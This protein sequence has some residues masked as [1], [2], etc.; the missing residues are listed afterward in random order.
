MKIASSSLR[1][2][3]RLK[4][5]TKCAQKHTY[6]LFIHTLFFSAI[7]LF[8]LPFMSLFIASL[9]SGSNGNCYYVGNHS[10]AVLI[11]AGI[12]C[13]EIERRMKR[14]DLS[15][16]KL[17]AVFISHEHADHTSGI[18]IFSKKHKLPVYITQQTLRYAG[19]SIEKQ[20]ITLLTMHLPVA[21]G[22]LNITAFPKLHDAAEPC[23][24]IV[25]HEGVVAGVFTDI[26]SPCE[27]VIKYFR[28]CHAAFLE[29]NYD[30]EM[31]RNGGYPFI[32]KKRISSDVGHL[33]N[34][35]A[36][37]LFKKH[38][39]PHMSHLFLSHLSKNNNSVPLVQQL[40]DAHAEN[41]HVV[42]AS[43]YHETHVYEI[44]VEMRGSEKAR[45]RVKATQLVF[46]F[47]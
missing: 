28:Q 10:E 13:R 40:F 46:E 8:S 27:Q 20:L 7:K 39:P 15:I 4:R 37:A 45:P 14:L 25:E 18:N 41:V 47:A 31:L 26:G 42:I 22:N 30:S 34:H 5:I 43:R 3:A 23:S 38:R 1:D 21:V 29:A 11:D 2:D 19:L 33:G 9:N 32:L 17:K 36:L 35:Q 6:E 12:S 16:Q 24:F 44:G